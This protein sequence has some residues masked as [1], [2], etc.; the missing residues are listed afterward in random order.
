MQIVNS[1]ETC[2]S[3]KKFRDVQNGLHCAKIIGLRRTYLTI[4]QIL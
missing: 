3:N 2:K 1:P 4:A